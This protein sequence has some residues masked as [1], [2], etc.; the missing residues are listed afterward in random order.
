[1]NLKEN[2]E[3]YLPEI[4]RNHKVMSQ[5]MAAFGEV[6]DGF[7]QSIDNFKH[8]NNYQRIDDNKLDYLAEQ[9]DITFLRNISNERK[10]QFLSEA[11]DL[12][13]TNGTEKSLLRIFRLIG[14]QVEL[15]YC[16]I[17]DPAY[18]EENNTD[19]YTLTSMGGAQIH[20]EKNEIVFGDERVEYGNVFVDIYDVSG[21]RFDNQPIYGES[22]GVLVPAVSFVKVPY[23]KVIIKANDYDLFT[24]DYVDPSTGNIYSYTEA[25]E[26]AI[27]EDIQSYFLDQSRPVHVA[28]LDITTPLTLVDR[29]VTSPK[30]FLTV[31]TLNTGAVIDGSV[32]VGGYNI[33]RYILG[34]SMGGFK[35]GT[36]D[37]SY[38]GIGETKPYEVINHIYPIGSTGAQKHYLLRDNSKLTIDIPEDTI[39]N[40]LTSRMPGIQI[41]KGNAQWAITASLRGGRSHTV[42]L[43]NRFG[44][45]INFTRELSRP[46]TIKLEYL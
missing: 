2:L 27:L 40:I 18:F 31:H 12:Y 15:D 33:D 5:L 26:Y 9:F 3:K 24:S 34:E 4:Y 13:R 25:E 35:V 17:V 11:I 36:N 46:V 21:N 32:V 1:M 42:E 39:V 23:V 22:Y 30:D 41:S 44:L 19:V 14:W 28:I 10:R 7:S 6:L 8:Y 20:I 45:L 37:M 29:I 16:W 43:K 38:Y